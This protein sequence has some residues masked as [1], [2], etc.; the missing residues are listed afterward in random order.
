MCARM[1]VVPCRDEVVCVLWTEFCVP[2]QAGLEIGRSQRPARRSV[3]LQPDHAFCVGRLPPLHESAIKHHIHPP[4]RM[5]TIADE[6]HVPVQRRFSWGLCF[7]LVGA[8]L[9]AHR[10]KKAKIRVL[11]IHCILGLLL[12]FPLHVLRVFVPACALCVLMFR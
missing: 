3:V 7:S 6:F 11:P 10:A 2:V 9:E 1:L 5:V 4:K 12:F 8:H